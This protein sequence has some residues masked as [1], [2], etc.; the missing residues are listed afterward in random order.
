MAV[1]AIRSEDFTAAPLAGVVVIMGVVA[2]TAGAAVTTAAADIMAVDT[3]AGVGVIGATLDMATATD[4][5]WVSALALDGALIGRLTHTIIRIIIPTMSL[6][7]L[8]ISIEIPAT[9][10]LLIPVP[11]RRMEM[12]RL[13]TQ[14]SQ[15]RKNI[16]MLTL[17][18]VRLSQLR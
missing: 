1:E 15:R 13:Q 10:A 2:I 6:M 17:T 14:A 4:G 16:P 9:V 5:G 7:G 8:I 11:T 12:N 3:T 18:L